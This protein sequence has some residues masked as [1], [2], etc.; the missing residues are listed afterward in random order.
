[1]TVRTVTTHYPDHELLRWYD[2]IME[3]EANTTNSKNRRNKGRANFCR[4][5]GIDPQKLQWFYSRFFFKEA[6]DPD[7]HIREVEIAKSYRESGLEKREFCKL[8]N[9]PVGKL[10]TA[11]LYLTYR[12]RLD[13]LLADRP[14]PLTG[15]ARLQADVVKKNEDTLEYESLSFH[16]VPTITKPIPPIPTPQVISPEKELELRT[17]GVRMFVT[18]GIGTE[19]LIKILEFLEGL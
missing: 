1:M 14:A 6:T 4:R 12:G 13:K 19:K 7:V 8:H 3:C 18:Y 2:L 16:Q 10:S 5:K 17:A 15:L 9:Y 11:D